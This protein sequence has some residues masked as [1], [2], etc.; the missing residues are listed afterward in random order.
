MKA[1]LFA[2]I[3]NVKKIHL[4]LLKEEQVQEKDGR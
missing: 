4:H 2:F 3:V 1:Q